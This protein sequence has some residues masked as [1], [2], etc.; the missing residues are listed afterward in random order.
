MA[1]SLHLRSSYRGPPVI[2][3]VLLL[4]AEGCQEAIHSL[5]RPEYERLAHPRMHR[6]WMGG[7]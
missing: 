7:F 1:K 5:P 3:I 6:L 2:S 4:R